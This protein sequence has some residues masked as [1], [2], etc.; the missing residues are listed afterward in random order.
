MNDL[1]YWHIRFLLFWEIIS[2]PIAKNTSSHK[3]VD[4]HACIFSSTRFYCSRFCV[5]IKI[6]CSFLSFFRQYCESTPVCS[7]LFWAMCCAVCE[8]RTWT[9][10]WRCMWPL[11]KKKKK[12][13]FYFSCAIFIHVVLFISKM[14][15]REFNQVWNKVFFYF[16]SFR[17]SFVFIIFGKMLLSMT[18]Y[19]LQPE[20]AWV[21]AR[22]PDSKAMEPSTRLLA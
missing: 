7:R 20:Q 18:S 13:H 4:T 3:P 9:E 6:L 10:N 21:K 14:Y 19:S 8:V 12:T 1:C 16:F 17:L 2:D 5:S 15:S 22:V 11:L